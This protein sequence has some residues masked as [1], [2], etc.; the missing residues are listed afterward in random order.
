MVA[1]VI[2]SMAVLAVNYTTTAGHQH[3]DL[4]EKR[5]RAVRLAGDLLEE[6]VSRPYAGAGADRSTFCVDDYNGFQEAP[7]ELKQAS[8]TLYGGEDQQCGRVASVTATTITVSELE[9]AVIPGKTVTVTVSD[10]DGH[11]WELSRFI[12]EPI[13]P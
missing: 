2:L 9:N 1:M 3:L 4:S 7:G 13:S 6:I 12:P 11:E 10:A 8:G 5:L